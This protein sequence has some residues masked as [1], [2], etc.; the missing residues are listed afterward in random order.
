MVSVKIAELINHE[1]IKGNK[2]GAAL[3]PDRPM[4]MYEQA[5]RKT[6]VFTADEVRSLLASQNWIDLR[7]IVQEIEQAAK[8]E[9][10]V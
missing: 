9:G 3:A 2:V 10:I 4:R 5:Q 7:R 8:G 1:M 6:P